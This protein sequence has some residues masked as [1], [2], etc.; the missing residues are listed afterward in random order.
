MFLDETNRYPV[1]VSTNL[2]EKEEEQLMMVLKMHRKAFGYSL[3]DLKGINPSIA[4][5]RIFMEDGAQ[6]LANFQWEL[7]P[8]IKGS[9]KKRNHP[10][11]RCMYHLSC[12]RK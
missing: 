10:P 7:K 5:Y 6:S 2:L 3:D 9:G 11:P 12:Q 1:I 4:T 8:E